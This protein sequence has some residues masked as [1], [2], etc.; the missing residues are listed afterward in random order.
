VINN[1]YFNDAAL[2]MLFEKANNNNRQPSTLASIED[3]V[4]TVFCADGGDVDG[5][6]GSS[7]TAQVPN[8]TPQALNMNASPPTFTTSQCD[9][10]A[11]HNNGLNV[12]FF[13]GHAKWLKIE[14]LMKRNALGRYVYL[15]K[16]LD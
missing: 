16:I 8:V 12:T 3:V 10:I 4:G 1:F 13:D 7:G 9:F 2:G 5:R 14:E 15:T 11:R 6:T